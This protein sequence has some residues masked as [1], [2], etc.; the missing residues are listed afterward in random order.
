MLVAALLV[1]SLSAVV[2]PALRTRAHAARA[3]PARAAFARMVASDGVR[4]G[5]FAV[6]VD[7]AVC[8]LF[9]AEQTA[10]VRRAWARLDAGEEHELDLDPSNPLMKQRA[11]SF[12]EGLS[13]HPWHEP[14]TRHKWAKKLE[15]EWTVVRD[16]LAAALADEGALEAQGNNVWAGAKNQTSASAYGQDW[17][18]LALCDRTV[19]DETNAALFPRTCELLHRAKVPLLEAFFAKMPPRST[20]GPHSD[21]CNFALTAHLGVDVPEGECSLTVGDG[22]REWRNGGAMLFDTSIL[23]EAENRADRT[24]YILMMRVYHPEL[25]AVERQALQFVFDCLDEPELLDDRVALREYPERR[26]AVEAASRISWERVL[27]ASGKGQR[28]AAGFAK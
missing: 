6:R 17:K 9:G 8:D 19:W 23:H 27:L 14:A 4:L 22:T 24:R 7:R 2:S 21:M 16:E 25:T 5:A 12:I 18:T 15:Q 10:R 26:R 3:A 1:G 20:I 11:S 13:A 28:R